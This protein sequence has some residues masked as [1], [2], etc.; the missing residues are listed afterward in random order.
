MFDNPTER[1]TIDGTEY[2]RL[3][4]GIDGEHGRK[5]N[6]VSKGRR[7]ADGEPVVL[8]KIPEKINHKII[9]EINKAIRVRLALNGTL[10]PQTAQAFLCG[11]RRPGEWCAT[12]FIPG[13]TLQKMVECRQT[14]SRF[15]PP[16][17]RVQTAINDAVGTLSTTSGWPPDLIHRDLKPGNIVVTPQGRYG[18]IDWEFATTLTELKK[19]CRRSGRSRG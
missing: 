17:H 5:E 16:S 8:R 4:E 18:I 10:D 13:K 15:I 19:P 11:E 1:I 6:H 14:S 3:E 2:E 7:L 12:T 9:E